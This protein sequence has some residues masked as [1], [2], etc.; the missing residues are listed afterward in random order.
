[1]QAGGRVGAELYHIH[2]LRGDLRIVYY[3]QY[4]HTR[5]W[6]LARAEH[7][8]ACAGCPGMICV[9]GAHLRRCLVALVKK[10]QSCAAALAS[11]CT[12]LPWQPKGSWWRLQSALR[13]SWPLISINRQLPR[14][15]ARPTTAFFTIAAMDVTS[16]RRSHNVLFAVIACV[17]TPEWPS[18]RWTSVERARSA[19]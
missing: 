4:L 6:V 14:A 11:A 16:V 1:M 8:R 18:A 17:G 9:Q 7:V 13:R 15:P 12:L 10:S 3:A 19:F 5:G 2:E